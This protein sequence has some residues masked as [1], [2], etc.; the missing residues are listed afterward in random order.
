MSVAEK[1]RRGVG[2]MFQLSRLF[3][4]FYDGDLVY[5]KSVLP[6]TE[7]SNGVRLHHEN[8]GSYSAILDASGDYQH[9]WA[10]PEYLSEIMAN[11]QFSGEY[12]LQNFLGVF[13]DREIRQL[14]ELDSF[15]SIVFRAEKSKTKQEQREFLGSYF[16]GLLPKLAPLNLLPISVTLRSGAESL[17]RLKQILEY[18][19]NFRFSVMANSTQRNSIGISSRSKLGHA[20]L[21]KGMVVGS[22]YTSLGSRITVG[23]QLESRAKYLDLIAGPHELKSIARLSRLHLP[24]ASQVNVEVALSCSES[25]PMKLDTSSAKRLKLGSNTK[26]LSD[27]SDYGNTFLY[28]DNK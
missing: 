23:I 17:P 12:T 4:R 16:A 13:A 21:G 2:S 22:S 11:Q 25:G 20:V 24:S 7:N 5:K 10:I 9:G 1:L 28:S 19:H 8:D 6:I 3:S 15:E 27:K 18:Y 26:L 14:I